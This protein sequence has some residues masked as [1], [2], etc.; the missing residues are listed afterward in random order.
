MSRKRSTTSSWTR[1]SNEWLPMLMTPAENG[2]TVAEIEKITH[3]LKE[4]G[5][6]AFLR[7]HTEASEKGETTSLR[8]LLLGFGVIPVR[9]PSSIS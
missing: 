2:F 5:L 1:V 3:E 7:K 9:S 8:K 6:I 4:R